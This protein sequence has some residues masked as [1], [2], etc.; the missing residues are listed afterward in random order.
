MFVS[1]SPETSSRSPAPEG[2]QVL[3]LQ[4]V[5]ATANPH[6]PPSSLRHLLPHW[7]FQGPPA[8]SKF[9]AA[10]RCLIIQIS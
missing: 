8:E 5:N 4:D 7:L 1:L 9:L 3:F 10:I 6:A 2:N